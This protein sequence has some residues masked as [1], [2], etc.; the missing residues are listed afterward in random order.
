MEQHFKYSESNNNKDMIIKLKHL[1][2]VIFHY[3]IAKRQRAI[4]NKYRS[5]PAYLG[6]ES[7]LIDSD[8]KSKIY[9]GKNSPRQTSVEWFNYGSCSL[10]GFG[11]YYVDK[12]KMKKTASLKIS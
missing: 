10:H 5:D 6:K 1:K 3:E 4:Y 12:K 8:Y 9:Y 11:I 7:I 2:S